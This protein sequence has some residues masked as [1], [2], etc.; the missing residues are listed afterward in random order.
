MKKMSFQEF[1]DSIQE[2]GASAYIPCL[3]RSIIKA[4]FAKAN[5][6]DFEAYENELEYA[7]SRLYLDK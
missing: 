3:G 5:G 6:F 2:K 7:Y 1:K 4:R